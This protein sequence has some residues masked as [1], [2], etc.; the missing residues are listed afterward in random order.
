MNKI[1]ISLFVLLA[2]GLPTARGAE[3]VE[4][5]GRVINTATGDPVSGVTV[6]LIGQDISRQS[7]ADGRFT[8]PNVAPGADILVL[9]SPTIISREISIQ[10]V[11]EA[12]E[13]D[14]DDI[15]VTVAPV[16]MNQALIG[17][18]D[19]SFL[20]DD[21][22]LGSQ[23]ISS[24]VILSNDIFLNKTG[25]QL[26]PFYFKVRGY[27]S[28][29][30]SKYINGI[31]FNDQY[32]GVFNYSSIGA[33]N[34]FTRYGDREHYDHPGTFTYGS[35]GGSENINIR[36]GGYSKGSKIT[37]SATNRN[38]Y[39]RLMGS[40]S[41][42]I[43]PNGWAFTF[44]AGGRY[45]DQ[46]NIEGTF[47]RN[48]SYL[49][50]AEKQFR[51][52]EHSLSFVSY[53]SP[54]ERG[55]QGSSFQEVYDLVG[56]NLYNPNWG[57]QN[58]KK[59]NSR[60][61]RAYDPT[62]ILSHIWKI[63]K[64]VS[65][66][67]G[68]GLH[69]NMY[70]TTALNWYDG[71]DPRPD[72]YRYLPSYQQNNTDVYKQYMLLWMMKEPGVVQIDWD[73]LYHINNLHRL[74]GNGAAIYMVEN[75]RNDMLETT[76]NSTLNAR[77]GDNNTL[78]AGVEL[79]KSQSMQ[80]KRVEDLLGAEYVYDIDK[81]AERDFQG[82]TAIIQNDLNR[83]ERIAREGDIFGYHFHL[84]IHSAKLWFMNRYNL[85]KMNLYYGAQI[86]YTDF[87]RTGF[88]KN[89][90]Y[91]ESSYGKG[92]NHNFTDFGVKAGAVYK[93][94]GRHLITANASAS[95]E[96]PLPDKA[97]I[98]PRVTDKTF[99]KLTSGKIYAADI[100]YIFSMKSLTGRFSLF[101]TEF[102]NQMDRISYYYDAANTFINHT[103]AGMNKRNRGMELGIKYKIDDHWSLDLAGTVAE[104]VY[105]NNPEG[106][107]SY[108]NGSVEGLQEKVYLKNY[109]L[110]GMPQTASTFAVNYFIN[111][112]FFSVHL[113]G[114]A[115]NYIEIAPIRRLVSNYENT[116]GHVGLIPTNPE[117]L[118]TYH[119]L[120]DQEKF[121]DAATLDLSIG[122]I[123]YLKN[124]NSFNF[125]FSLNNILNTKTI[126]TGGYE[127]G[128]LDLSYPDRYNS[129]YYYAQGLNFY[130]NS[131]YKF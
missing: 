115:N 38:Y 26:S 11:E 3:I 10:I 36:A 112:W 19:E 60:I 126:R 20:D 124:R 123:Y 41:T 6:Q 4:I 90:R 34:D 52:G 13:L 67:S 43:M 102:T 81:F 12:G 88:M 76:F 5:K 94:S 99:G 74:S 85:R 40:Y 118:E 42:G 80:Y 91:P 15:K 2:L 127:S 117:D 83:P 93:L 109:R 101:Q 62:G 1:L 108:E 32:R 46:G 71:A 21:T 27:S 95:M 31:N 79:R 68:V 57:Y 122:K 64:D 51:G 54:V 107:I 25:F 114:M 35:V 131:S 96:S 116:P 39:S 119:L 73:N 56:N 128:R 105:S 113:N 125:N 50:S 129:K 59:R 24:M 72:Y 65:L 110:G 53:G 75:R 70:G 23:G 49:F 30:E 29:Y 89:G 37:V 17:I 48:I 98:S 106:Y 28:N 16:E 9:S 63:N 69:F 87:Y 18:I 78:T 111:Y 14:F 97:Y 58:G 7:G 104:Y 61:V 44:G 82:N 47:Y 8:I 100:N 92:A 77:F 86:K 45:S 22:E 103:L 66:T 33:L 120:T 130:F 84:D 55:Q 121:A